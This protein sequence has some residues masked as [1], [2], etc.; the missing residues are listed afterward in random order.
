[1]LQPDL[2][3]PD[4]TLETKPKANPKQNQTKTKQK[5]N[6]PKRNKLTTKRTNTNPTTKPPQIILAQG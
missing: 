3:T 2:K 5:Q 6:K 1:M 4:I